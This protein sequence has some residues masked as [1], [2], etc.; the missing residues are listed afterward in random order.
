MAEMLSEVPAN[1][2]LRVKTQV[3]DLCVFVNQIVSKLQEIVLGRHS[4]AA[5]LDSPV[6]SFDINSYMKASMSREEQLK[7]GLQK[8]MITITKLGTLFSIDTKTSKIIWKK[9]QPF[10]EGFTLISLLKLKEEYEREVA[11]AISYSSTQKIT[12]IHRYYD[13]LCQHKRRRG[14]KNPNQLP[15]NR[16]KAVSI[17]NIGPLAAVYLKVKN[18]P[19]RYQ[20]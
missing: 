20:F 5:S 7:Y 12:A 4:D 8:Y 2:M 10:P 11:I 3:E 9:S 19:I 16:R 17:Q 13:S 6:E 15:K 1:F 14:D 18:Q